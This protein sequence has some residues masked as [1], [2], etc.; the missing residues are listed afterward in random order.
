MG[1]RTYW[2]CNNCYKDF[3][4]ELEP[5]MPEEVAKAQG[6]PEVYFCPFCGSDNIDVKITEED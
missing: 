1:I 5:S 4:I 2:E 6:D 3:L